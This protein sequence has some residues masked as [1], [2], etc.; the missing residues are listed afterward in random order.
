MRYKGN[1][2]NV[3]FDRMF[4]RKHTY[5]IELTPRVIKLIIVS[6]IKITLHLLGLRGL[7]PMKFIIQRA[8]GLKLPVIDW[9]TNEQSIRDSKFA[10]AFKITFQLHIYFRFSPINSSS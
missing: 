7:C 1:H 8:V 5:K 9:R 6:G 10:S 3:L 4:L 2:K